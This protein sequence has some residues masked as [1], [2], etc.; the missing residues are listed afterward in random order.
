M[1][2]KNIIGITTLMKNNSTQYRML[3]IGVGNTGNSV[4]ESIKGQGIDGLEYLTIDE[5]LSGSLEKNLKKTDM[6]V[7]VYDSCE[8]FDLVKKAL[9]V[10]KGIDGMTTIAVVRSSFGYEQ[11]KV[12]ATSKRNMRKIT[13]KVDVL[14]EISGER[15]GKLL[16]NDGLPD[17][18]LKIKSVNEIKSVV[19][20]I[21][22]MVDTLC[23][24]DMRMNFNDLRDALKNKGRSYI[25]IGEGEGKEKASKAIDQAINNSIMTIGIKGA[26]SVVISVIGNIRLKDTEIIED[27]FLDMFGEDIDILFCIT[28]EETPGDKIRLT[29]LAAGIQGES[30]D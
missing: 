12:R 7:I 15:I 16:K 9:D 6:A 10:C 29:L 18:E 19:L 17:D 4:I 30:G 5:Q 25:G 3:T 24:S 23:R 20:D 26:K 28:K 27:F 11:E 1:K 22:N 8:K 14:I 13:D 21:K 2:D